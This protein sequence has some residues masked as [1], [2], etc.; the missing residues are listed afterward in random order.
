M[1]SRNKLSVLWTKGLTPKQKEDFET[2]F[3]GSSMFREK[4][5]EII[6]GFLA[7]IDTVETSFDNPNWAYRQANLVGQRK[8][9][10]DIRNLINL[11]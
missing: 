9:L 7:G 11:G 3:R 1:S 2:A 4:L 6:D 5:T 10:N 8:A